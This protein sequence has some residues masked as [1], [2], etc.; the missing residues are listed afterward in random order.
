MIFYGKQYLDTQDIISVKKVLHGSLITQGKN[1]E[2]FEKKLS[3]FFSKHSCVVSSGTAALHLSLIAIDIKKGDKVLLSPITFVASANA[4]LYCQAKIDLVDI[5][6][7]DY[8]LDTNLL[9]QKLKKDKKIKAVIVTDYAGQPSNWKKL[10]LL[11][12]KY[13]FK[14]INDCCHAIGAKYEN[15]I[16]YAT[17]YADLVTYSFHPVKSFTTGEGGAVLSNNKKYIEKIKILRSHGIKKK[18]NDLWKYSI[19]DLG[20]NYRITDFQCA[21]G[22]S[23]LNKLNKFISKR[24]QIAKIYMDNLKGVRNITLPKKILKT[25]SAYHLFPVLINFSNKMTRKKLFNFFLKKKIS[26]QVHYIPIYNH[27]LYNK[28]FKFNRKFFPNSEKFY[29]KQVSLPIF[30][31]LKVSK[32]LEICDL[33]KNFI[34]ENSNSKH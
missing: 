30:Y 22:C 16:N 3:S 1:I 11:K 31:D 8:S 32:V 14:L 10:K 7:D 33:L 6:L 15:K 12:K 21:L 5:N 23:Q 9:E 17:K 24:R 34:N 20:Y 27:D 18:Y 19:S 13:N 26:L 25:Q 4:V 29:K 2:I 28:K